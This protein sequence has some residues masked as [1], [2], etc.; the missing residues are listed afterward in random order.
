MDVK[1]SYEQDSLEIGKKF[2][3]II[4]FSILFSLSFGVIGFFLINSLNKNYQSDIQSDFDKIEKITNYSYQLSSIL[5]R[6]MI[7]H[8][9]KNLASFN[10][11][12][13]NLSKTIVSLKDRYPELNIASITS[14]LKDISSYLEK[15]KSI[16]I[17]SS[18][19]LIEKKLTETK[20]ILNQIQ[21]TSVNKESVNKILYLKNYARELEQSMNDLSDNQFQLNKLSQE[22]IEI[23]KKFDT[24]LNNFRDDAALQAN[25]RE[26]SHNTRIAVLLLFSFLSAIVILSYSLIYLYKIKRKNDQK[27]SNMIDNIHESSSIIGE[28]IEKSL[29]FSKEKEDCQLIF[30]KLSQTIQSNLDS[31]KVL[32]EKKSDFEYRMNEILSQLKNDYLH[33]QELKNNRTMSKMYDDLYETILEVS[34]KTQIIDDIVFQSKIL[35][36]NAAVEAERAGEMGRGFSVVAQEISNLSKVSGSA[37]TEISKI[38]KECLNVINEQGAVEKNSC[39]LSH[40]EVNDLLKSIDSTSKKFEMML[41]FLNDAFLIA[42]RQ[43][44]NF[45]EVR[46]L[47]E[48]LSDK[49]K[50]IS[51]GDDLILSIKSENENIS[52]NRFISK[53]L[54]SAL[55][56]ENMKEIRNKIPVKKTVEKSVENKYEKIIPFDSISKNSNSSL[57][58]KYVIRESNYT[59]KTY[60]HEDSNLE[61]WDKL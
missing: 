7:Y 50:K 35:S 59:K 57:N 44:N 40:D 61:E 37:A 19:D 34:N 13:D 49:Y 23:D 56:D 29:V 15:Y 47:F 9:E 20:N 10:E 25:E 33:L 52:L 36:F 5:N 17:N 11:I 1:N 39:K 24:T 55:I 27:I 22:F 58:E 38:V 8:E 2:K 30:D 4:Y 16:K 42:D 3:N 53:N 45:E 60:S 14:I 6:Y 32:E 51:A 21:K 26:L 43:D 31:K 28:K 41:R 46:S 18:H 48:S 54:K 12:Y